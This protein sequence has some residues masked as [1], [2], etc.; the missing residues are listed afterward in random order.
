M[1]NILLAGFLGSNNSAKLILDYASD[2]LQK[3]YLKN[4]FCLCANQILE[5]ISSNFYDLIVILGQ[6]PTIKSIYIELV[7]KSDIDYFCSNYDYSKL[8]K[9]IENFGY[10]VKVSSNAGNYLCNH[11]YYHGLR[12]LSK[13]NSKSYIIFIHVPYLK[14]FTDIKFFAT[15]LSDCLLNH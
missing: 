10:K 12:T 11:V 6:K 4:D 15:V 3:L 9:H 7:G 13:I 1:N 14:N 8:Q 5:S 2:D